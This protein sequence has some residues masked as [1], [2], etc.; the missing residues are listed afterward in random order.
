M[1]GPAPVGG[2]TT[3]RA[4]LISGPALFTLSNALP[5]MVAIL[6]GPL[7]L[8]KVGVEQYGILGLATYILSLASIYAD[9][10]AYP[11]LIAAFSS[12]APDRRADLAAAFALK[13]MVFLLLCASLGSMVLLAPRSDSLYTVVA[14]FFLSIPIAPMNLD[15]YLIVRNRYD[16]LLVA[17]LAASLIQV[18]LLTTWYLSGP[19]DL[20]PVAAIAVISGVIG[21]ASLAAAI[22]KAGLRAAWECLGGV[23]LGAIRSLGSRLL[24]MTATQLVAPYFLAY[25]MAWFA[26]TSADP[27]LEGAF[28]IGYRLIMGF[29][30]LLGPLVLYALAGRGAGTAEIPFLKVLAVSLFGMTL[31]WLSGLL[32][33]WAFFH[34]GEVDPS[35]LSFTQE[36]FSILLAGLLFQALRIVPVSRCLAAGRYLPYFL[37]HAVGCLPVLLLSRILGDRLPY[38]WVPALACVPDALATLGF[39]WYFRARKAPDGREDE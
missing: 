20:L 33:I 8:R 2:G 4:R 28:S 39:T 25:A 12:R 35:L 34:F 18:G 30:S 21:S 7:V 1:T 15:W 17:R 31:F 9:F 38:T 24:P 13:G 22:G 3:P 29:S 16:H 27:R 10:G 23:T 11:H 6:T 37:I 5:S 36:T 26:L 19:D 32:I 14:V